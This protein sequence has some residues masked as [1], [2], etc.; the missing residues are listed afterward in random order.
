VLLTATVAHWAAAG[1]L[2]HTS[3][4]SQYAS[5][6]Y[7]QALQAAGIVCSMSRKGNCWDRAPADSFF[8]N[9]KVEEPQHFKFDTR[10]EAR[11]KVLRYICCTTPAAGTRPLDCYPL[12]P[13]KL[14]PEPPPALP[15]TSG[16]LS[17]FF[18]QVQNDH[19]T[20]VVA[21]CG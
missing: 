21:S 9:A 20:I 13:S 10:D 7:R 8:A 11:D 14:K 2:H 19:P 15:E 16:H 1:L 3:L 17:V 12:Q 18:A 6:D 5:C 4:G